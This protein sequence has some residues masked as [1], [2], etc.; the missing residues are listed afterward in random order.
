VNTRSK[1]RSADPAGGALA[2]RV[3]IVTGSA[4]GRDP[5]PPEPWRRPG[6]DAVIDGFGDAAGITKVG[7]DLER[8]FSVGTIYSAA[9]LSMPATTSSTTSV[10]NMWRA[11]ETFAP[12]KWDAIIA[13][14]LS[15]AF[16]AIGAVVHELKARS[17]PGYSSR[18]SQSG[19]SPCSFAPRRA[20]PSPALPIESVRAAQ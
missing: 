20:L 3:A 12:T 7:D 6:A 13:T 10:S 8:C 14:D 1:S 15:A 4:S 2:G 18:P 19:P 17:R 16:H 11:I 9:N 5:G